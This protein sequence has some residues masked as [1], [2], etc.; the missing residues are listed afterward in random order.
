VGWCLE[1]QVGLVTLGP[2]TCGI[3]QEVEAWGQQ[4][5]SLPLFVDKPARRRRDAPRRWDGRSLTREVEVE[6]E[7]G[8]V[9]LAPIRFVAV[10]STQLAQHQEAASGKAQAREAEA[11]AEHGAQV[12]RRRFAC[13][14]DAQAA[15][16]EYEGRGPGKRG[17]RPCRWRYHAVRYEVEA[18]WQRKPRTHRGRPRKDEAVEHE[19]VDRLPRHSKALSPLVSTF[20]GLVL[21][22]TVSEHTCD[23]AE[24]VRAYREQTTTVEPGFRWIK[25]PA[26]ISPVWVEKRERIAALAMLTVGG[27][28]V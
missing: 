23:D 13:E 3:R 18:Q 17:R 10:Y 2:R 25:H 16:A 7:D 20:G 22:T 5:S 8:R 19:R 24:I 21:A 11:V 26:A 14:A 12:Q 1:Q 9:A 27:F 15:I 6:Y 28:L 4:H